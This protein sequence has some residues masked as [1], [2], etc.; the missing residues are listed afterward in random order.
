MKSAVSEV[1]LVFLAERL[2]FTPKKIGTGKY[3]LKEMDSLVIFNRKTW[4]RFSGKGN[5]TGSDQVDF[6][7]EFGNMAYPEAM[8]YLLES[9]GYPLPERAG[10]RE[11]TELKQ[12][13]QR[14]EEKEVEKVPFV[15]PK[16]S[17][18]YERLYQYLMNERKLS[19][20]VIAFFI[21]KGL[22]YESLPYHNLVFVGYDPKGEAKFANMR[23]T[24]E[25]SE[26]GKKPFRM[27]VA[28]NDKKYGVNLCN[29]DSKDL[30]VF[31]A[32]IDAM[33]F[34]ELYHVQKDNLLVLGGTWDGALEQFLKDYAHIKSITFCLDNDEAGRKATKEYMKKYETRGYDTNFE[35]PEEGKDFNEYL[36]L[37][38]TKEVSMRYPLR[39]AAR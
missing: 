9:I 15:L 1:D 21:Q 5:K 22:L 17:W 18:N 39:Q 14:I 7:E 8:L 6:L 31:E 32:A 11:K 12:P 30:Y 3:N 2:G 23:G 35:I 20:E 34:C 29:P 33:S 19:K 4:H 24:F 13:L 37:L 16:R 26:S 38:R 36:K 28:G 10:Q 27:D 25:P